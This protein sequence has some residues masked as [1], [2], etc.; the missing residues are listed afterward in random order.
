[1]QFVIIDLDKKRP[2]AQQKLVEKYYEGFIP[3]VVLLDKNGKTRYNSA[4][5]VDESTISRILDKALQ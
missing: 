4:G 1:M 2:P 5:E 3:H